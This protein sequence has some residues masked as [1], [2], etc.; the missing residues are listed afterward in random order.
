M[1]ILIINFRF[2]LLL[3]LSI[4]FV[5][6]KSSEDDSPL[7]ISEKVV[8]LENSEWLLK[9]FEDRVK[10]TFSNGVKYTFYG[11]N[12]QFSETPIPGT[13]SYSIANNRLI[14]SVNNTNY[15]YELVFSCNNTIVSL[16]RDNELHSVLY[17]NY[18]NYKECL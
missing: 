9:G 10:H 7:S 18:S 13:Q 1:K 15:E 12:N 14:I 8:L 2:L 3:F 6:C 16:F 5:N 4:A 11:Q 17:E